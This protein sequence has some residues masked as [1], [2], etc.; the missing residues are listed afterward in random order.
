MYSESPEAPGG[1][2]EHRVGVSLARSKCS[3]NM[4]TVYKLGRTVKK[5]VLSV[6]F[7]PHS[8]S[9]YGKILKSSKVVFHISDLTISDSN[10]VCLQLLSCF[11]DPMALLA[12]VGVHLGP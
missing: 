4:N 12:E 3:L 9:L 1:K 7:C 6:L 2:R 11:L 5:S 8:V 10:K